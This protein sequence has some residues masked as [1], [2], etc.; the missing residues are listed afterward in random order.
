MKNENISKAEKTKLFIIEKAAP[1]FNKKGYTGTAISDIMKITGL[2][3]GCIYG[4]FKDKNEIAIAAFEY[5]M[6][7]IFSN[8]Y[9]NVMQYENCLDRLH[10]L[11]R[12][13]K[14]LYYDDSLKN[15]C[16]I[17][18]T[19]I[20][21]DDTNQLVFKRVKS[22]VDKWRK[23]LRKIIEEGREKGEIKIS[24]IPDEFATNVIAVIEGGSM[25]FSM[26]KDIEYIERAF[27]Q[28]ERI[29]NNELA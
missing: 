15:G 5:N 9:D 11:L 23:F 12:C 29:I 20:D 25:L 8:I 21:V 10:E 18:N 7:K 16:P 24:V 26:Y 19:S 14:N 6:K 1:I 2:S 13:H 27:S 17:L 28:L 4:N 3:K 22:S